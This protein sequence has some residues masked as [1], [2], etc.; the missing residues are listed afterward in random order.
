MGSPLHFSVGK[1]PIHVVTAELERAGISVYP[2]EPDAGVDRYIC[3]RDK[4]R[5]EMWVTPDLDS[6]KLWLMFLADLS[7][8]CWW[9]IPVYLLSAASELRLQRDAHEALRKFSDGDDRSTECP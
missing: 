9:K 8:W 3:K 7:G 1:T 5:F 4:A 6:G 2:L